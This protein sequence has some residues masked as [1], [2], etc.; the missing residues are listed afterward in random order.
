RDL[1]I[2]VADAIAREDA[3]AVFELAGRASESGYDLRLVIRELA[4]LARDLLVLTVDPSRASDPEIAAEAEREPLLALA[5]QSSGEDLMRAFD[6]LTKAEFDIRSSM[7]PRYHVEM[8][9]LR[10]IH[11][12]KLVPLTDL[13]QQVSGPG[14]PPPGPGRTTLDSSVG[15]AAPRPGSRED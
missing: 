15:S 9:L 2:E 13:I 10:W 8:A 6:V 11:L 12:R 1:L 5:K 3:T 7:Q 4:R 14:R